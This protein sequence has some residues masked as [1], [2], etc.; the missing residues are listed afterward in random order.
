MATAD[1]GGAILRKE[2]MKGW[3]VLNRTRWM[4]ENGKDAMD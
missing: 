1:V 3:Y 2:R 4:S